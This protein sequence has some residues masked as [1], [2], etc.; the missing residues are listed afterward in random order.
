MEIYDEAISCYKKALTLDPNNDGYK[1]NLQIAEEKQKL[2]ETV[3]CFKCA[4]R[5]KNTDKNNINEVP[6]APLNLIFF[7]NKV[8][9]KHPF[10][11]VLQGD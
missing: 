6:E 10:L 7:W 8:V 1:K 5:E 11:A 2:R 3:S 9:L 4:V